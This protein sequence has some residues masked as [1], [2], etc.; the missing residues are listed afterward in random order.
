MA[1]ENNWNGTDRFAPFQGSAVQRQAIR[2]ENFSFVSHG[3]LFFSLHVLGGAAGARILVQLHG[4]LTTM[5]GSR[6]RCKSTVIVLQAGGYE[7]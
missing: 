7:R 4:W 6:N 2:E 1:F 5:P 3:V